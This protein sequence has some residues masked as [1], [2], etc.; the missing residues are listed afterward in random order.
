MELPY[1]IEFLKAVLYIKKK[2]KIFGNLS[3]II[4]GT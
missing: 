2:K 4:N 3:S 1:K